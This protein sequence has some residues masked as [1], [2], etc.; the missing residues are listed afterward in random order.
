M[1]S[2]TLATFIV[3]FFLICQKTF[4]AANADWPGGAEYLRTEGS[5]LFFKLPGDAN[6][7]IS[8]DT[9]LK[10]LKW[11]QKINATEPGTKPYFVVSG[12][13]CENC[14]S[15]EKSIFI[16]RAAEKNPASFIYPGLIRDYNTKSLIFSSRAF[17][18]NCLPG[19]SGSLVVFQHEKLPRMRY[20]QPSVIVVEAKRDRLH[21]KLYIKNKP[22]LNTVI[23][24][25]KRK[26]CVEI[27][28]FLRFTQKE[29]PLLRLTSGHP[30]NTSEK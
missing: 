5:F 10:N 20:L 23:Q 26:Q 12:N 3:F 7:H 15:N 21:E 18:G 2:K 11:I 25:V 27:R 17:A 24:Q 29:L 14:L 13:L 9:G 22:Q 28:G 6:V 30:K 8:M 4:W 16:F 1:Y 19:R